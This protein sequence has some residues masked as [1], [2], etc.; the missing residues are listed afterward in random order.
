[1]RDVALPQ[2]LLAALQRLQ[3]AGAV[4]WL[5]LV[6]LPPPPAHAP[7]AGAHAPPGSWPA[8]SSSSSSGGSS[9][10]SASAPHSTGMRPPAGAAG[11]LPL[12][13]SLGV[14]LFCPVLCQLV[15]DSMVAH[16][17]LSAA[18]KRAWRDAQQQLLQ[19][20]EQ[21]TAQLQAGGAA[22]ADAGA[23][24]GSSAGGSSAGPAGVAELPS[25]ALL[26][27]GRRLMPVDV[28]SCLQGVP[29]W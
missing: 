7:W 13:L 29:L 3:L 18:G 23:S 4:G 11:W 2:Q 5:R 14:P 10:S 25:H 8:S 26:F 12:S 9:G 27:D 19:Q 20:L 6:K 16:G 24:G 17:C 15:C 1:V 28:S 22:A 21:H